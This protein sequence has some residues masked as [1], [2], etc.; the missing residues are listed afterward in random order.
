MQEELCTRGTTRTPRP[1]QATYARSTSAAPDDLY[2][3]HQTTHACAAA[4][5][6]DACPQHKR[7]NEGGGVITIARPDQAGAAASPDT[8]HTVGNGHTRA[9][10]GHTETPEAQQPHAKEP[11]VHKR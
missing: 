9:A 4:Q 6:G 8:S 1:P 7:C 3:H 11:H 10:E 2:R 5:T